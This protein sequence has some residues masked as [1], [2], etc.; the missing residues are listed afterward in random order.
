MKNQNIIPQEIIEKKIYF[1]RDKKVM[2]D[3]DL[4]ELYGVETRVLNQ[5][6]R[7]NIDRFPEDFMFSLTRDEIRDL[8]QI[9]I[10]S[11]IKHAPNVF[12]FTEHGIAM[13]SSVLRS[14]RAIKVNIAIMRTFIKLQEYSLSYKE[15]NEKIMKLEEKYDKHDRQF[16]VVFETLKKMLMI[17]ED[18]KKRKIG[19]KPPKKSKE[20][21]KGK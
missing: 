4:A 9:V 17:Q 21:K 1:I 3:K 12:V 5:A 11:K 8:S 20:E 19:F 13:L 16:Q 18:K 7:R 2:L 10:S 15:I 14:D 6:V